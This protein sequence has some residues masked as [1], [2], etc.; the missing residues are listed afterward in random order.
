MKLRLKLLTY[1]VTITGIY[2]PVEGKTSE[3][4]EFYDE[5]QAVYDK[6]YKSYYLIL[7]GDFNARV[8]A[9]PVD[10]CTGSQGEQTVN[11]NGTDLIHFCL[12]N[13]LSHKHLFQTEYT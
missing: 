12:F 2:T 10:K 7:T 3:R 6:I 11:N 4:E 8:G 5:L 9:Q 13:K 1:T